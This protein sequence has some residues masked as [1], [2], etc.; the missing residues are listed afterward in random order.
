MFWR[1]KQKEAAPQ[2]AAKGKQISQQQ[3]EEEELPS[4]P[5]PATSGSGEDTTDVA[6][7]DVD[8]GLS[9]TEVEEKVKEPPAVVEDNLSPEE[10]LELKRQEAMQWQKV[11]ETQA[12]ARNSFCKN[13]RVEYLHKT[14]GRQFEAV[15]VDVHLDDGI[16]RPYFTVRYQSGSPPE[17]I[18]K[19]TTGDRLSHVGFDEAKTYEIISSKIKF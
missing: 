6:M 11:Q 3:D 7:E 12:L 10:R 2:E 17:M 15:V 18:E 1:R 4:P 8:E 19:Q 5:E 9:E 13:Q 16:D 14:T